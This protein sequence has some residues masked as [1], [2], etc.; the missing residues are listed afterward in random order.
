M[1]KSKVLILSIVGIVYASVFF[2]TVIKV[3]S[4]DSE[5]ITDDKKEYSVYIDN[6]GYDSLQLALDNARN[7]DTIDIRSDLTESVK[8]TNKTVTINGNNHTITSPTFTNTLINT[9]KAIISIDEGTLNIRNL[10]IDGKANIDA[11]FANIGI[12][13]V[14]SSITLEN[15]IIDNINHQQNQLNKYPYGTGIY[16]VND[17]EVIKDIKLTNV[18]INNFHQTGVYINN[19]T[20]IEMAVAI[21]QCTI[22][23][24]GQTRDICQRGIVLLG[25]IKGDISN[26]TISDLRF[27]GMND[28]GT[29]ILIKNEMHNLV[30]TNN[31]C[32]NVDID[33]NQEI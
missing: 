13:A 32:V 33:K 4:S 25:N 11:S 9:T 24:L 17:S 22:K 8:I 20:T 7:S 29:A 26:N 15:V 6:Q 27:L 10:K 18:K 23:G 3:P 21:D 16:I 31:T 5:I 14:S 1:T 19:R 28:K 12:Y 30:L 2:G